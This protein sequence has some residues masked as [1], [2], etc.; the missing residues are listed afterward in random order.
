MELIDQTMKRF[1]FLYFVKP[2]GRLH[3]S[4]VFENVFLNR[5][6]CL[7]GMKLNYTRGT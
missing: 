1:K 5:I 4:G 7:E 6:F 3:L 2:S